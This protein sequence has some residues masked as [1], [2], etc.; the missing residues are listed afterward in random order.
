M[1]VAMWENLTHHS[2]APQVQRETHMTH[3]MGR[4]QVMSEHWD[5]KYTFPGMCADTHVY[6]CKMLYVKLKLCASTLVLLVAFT[7]LPSLPYLHVCMK[8]FSLVN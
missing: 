3:F 4:H 8:A 7:I 5:A 6:V 2:F 1:R